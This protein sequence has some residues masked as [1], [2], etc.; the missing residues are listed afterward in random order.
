LGKETTTSPVIEVMSRISYIRF[1]TYTMIAAAFVWPSPKRHV[2]PVDLTAPDE[3]GMLVD[4]AIRKR[5]DAED[6]ARK[7][8]FETTKRSGSEVMRLALALATRDGGDLSDYR[9][10]TISLFQRDEKMKWAVHWELKG[11][12]MPGGFFGVVVDDETGDATLVP[13]M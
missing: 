4:A 7:P 8:G 11:M 6:I 13:G 1:A 9:A 10:P 3:V 12:P 2:I 5:Q